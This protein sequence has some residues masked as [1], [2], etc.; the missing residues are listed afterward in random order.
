MLM[1]ASESWL[2]VGAR[3]VRAPMPGGLGFTRVI[4]SPYFLLIVLCLLPCSLVFKKRKQGL[5][6]W[7][8]GKESTCQCRRRESDPS[9]GKIPCVSEQL[10]PR[11]TTSEPV[12]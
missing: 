4:L 10:S 2:H 8:S 9:S 5:S 1:C 12:L 11:V 3:H 7:P 6:W